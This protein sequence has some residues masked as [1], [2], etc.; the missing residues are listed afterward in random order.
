[1]TKRRENKYNTT[2][3]R[4]S[5]AAL[6]VQS[7]VREAKRSAMEEAESFERRDARGRKGRKK[8]NGRR[9][10]LRRA[11]KRFAAG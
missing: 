6:C 2:P 1:M 5:S 4:L 8:K 10:E 7:K 9:D 11:V 3:E